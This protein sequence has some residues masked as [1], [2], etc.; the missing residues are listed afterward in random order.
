M[1]ERIEFN[2]G[3]LHVEPLG[4]RTKTLDVMAAHISS[5]FSLCHPSA[6]SALLQTRAFMH[7]GARN[8]TMQNAVFP[9]SDKLVTARPR[10]PI[11]P[12]S[13]T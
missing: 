5:T 9:L 2:L 3:I 6:V 10:D 11:V 1:A 4:C 8:L 7:D 13:F 12:M